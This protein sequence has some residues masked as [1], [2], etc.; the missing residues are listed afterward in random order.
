[1]PLVGVYNLFWSFDKLKKESI[2]KKIEEGEG[3]VIDK[4]RFDIY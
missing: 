1:M 2:T 3:D 4:G